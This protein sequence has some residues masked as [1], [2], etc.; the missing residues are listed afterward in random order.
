[1]IRDRQRSGTMPYHCHRPHRDHA[2]VFDRRRLSARVER[3][4][5]GSSW[6][7]ATAT[8]PLVE[9]MGSTGRKR[10]FFGLRVRTGSEEIEVGHPVSHSSVGRPVGHPSVGRPFAS[11]AD[12]GVVRRLAGPAATGATGAFPGDITPVVF[13][14]RPELIE[15]TLPS[16][17]GPLRAVVHLSTATAPVRRENGLVRDRDKVFRAVREAAAPMVR[18]ADVRPG[19]DLRSTRAEGHGD[20]PLSALTDALADALAG[21]GIAVDVLDLTEHAPTAV[22]TGSAGGAAAY[23]RC[24]G[25]DRTARD[26]GPDISVRTAFVRAVFSAVDPGSAR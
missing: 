15:R 23:A 17:D 26:A 12:S 3:A 19:T 10:H 7:C 4:P 14:A 22:T 11:R 25:G 21:A 2:R 16:P 18:P 24:R 20:G 9:P 1:M 13:T 5:L 6:I 8:G